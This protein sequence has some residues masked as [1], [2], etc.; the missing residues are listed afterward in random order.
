[1]RILCWYG[2]ENTADSADKGMYLLDRERGEAVP[3]ICIA[4]KEDSFVVLT[5]VPEAEEKTVA[6][7]YHHTLCTF[8]NGSIMAYQLTQ[9]DEHVSDDVTA[10]DFTMYM[11]SPVK[12]SA[13]GMCMILLVIPCSAA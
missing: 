7:C 6:D 8:G 4:G 2:W 9:E 3:F 13:D 11:E 10:T 5:D 1:M 12:V